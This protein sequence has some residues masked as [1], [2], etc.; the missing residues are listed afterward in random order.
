MLA[1]RAVLTYQMVI[2]KMIFI[3]INNFNARLL[4]RHVDSSIKG[5]GVFFTPIYGLEDILL[6][7]F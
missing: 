6:N 4:C 5:K 3:G 7:T 2:F 1:S